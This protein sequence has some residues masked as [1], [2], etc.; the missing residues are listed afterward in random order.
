MSSAWN[1]TTSSTIQICY[2]KAGFESTIVK[3]IEM[4][5]EKDPAREEYVQAWVDKNKATNSYDF[6]QDLF[7]S[8]DNEVPVGGIL[9]D[10]E[11][12]AELTPEPACEEPESEIPPVYVWKHE[13]IQGI[14]RM[15]MY[16]FM[17]STEDRSDAL[18]FLAK[19][20]WHR[21][22]DGAEKK[23][24]KTLFIFCVILLVYVFYLVLI[25]FHFVF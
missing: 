13:A 15:Q 23:P 25:L 3:Q 20:T 19:K 6:N 1:T 10:E 18:K 17:Q 22:R 5:F 8:I 21:K 4:Q 16:L 11:I 14:Q 24:I 2:R 9:T 12:L 7:L